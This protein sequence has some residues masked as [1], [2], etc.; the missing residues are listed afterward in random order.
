MDIQL[1]VVRDFA[2]HLR[3]D[4]ITD[5]AEIAAVLGGAHADCVVRVRVSGKGN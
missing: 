4:V 5:A 2:A 1:V 3:G